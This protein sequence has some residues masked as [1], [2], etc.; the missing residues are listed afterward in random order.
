[1][2]KIKLSFR[3]ILKSVKKRKMPDFFK[4][5]FIIIT[6]LSGAL[7]GAVFFYYTRS[8]L[9]YDAFTEASLIGVGYDHSFSGASFY[10]TSAFILFFCLLNI[11]IA[12]IVYAYDVLAAYILVVSVPLINIIYF[13]STLI[14]FSFA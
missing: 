3:D 14:L 6:V 8:K 4:D 12:R 7:L 1:M 2:I 5:I 11:I 10:N 9:G 13:T